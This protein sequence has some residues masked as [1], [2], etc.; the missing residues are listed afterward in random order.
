MC[1]T[2][3]NELFSSICGNGPFV[4]VEA[5]AMALSACLSYPCPTNCGCGCNHCGCNNCGCGCNSCNSCNNTI[6]NGCEC[7]PPCSSTCSPSPVAVHVTIGLFAVVKLF[8][9]SNMMVQNLGACVPEEATQVSPE[10]CNPCEFF[11]NLDFPVNLFA[12]QSGYVPSSEVP[13]ASN[14]G[15]CCSNDCGCGGSCGNCG[16]C[17]C[18]GCGGCGNCGCK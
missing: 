16:N 13:V 2:T 9:L 10:S 4:G 5:N 11:Q 6:I 17:G 12:P 8:R 7:T 18:G 3:F 1:V 15:G 14:N